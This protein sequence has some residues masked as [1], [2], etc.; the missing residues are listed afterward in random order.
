[1]TVGLRHPQVNRQVR[2]A[3]E[4]YRVVEGNAPAPV[5]F[6]QAVNAQLPAEAATVQRNGVIGECS[7][8]HRPRYDVGLDA[9][10][11]SVRLVEP[12]VDAGKIA[13]CDRG[14]GQRRAGRRLLHGPLRIEK[15]NRR[16][17][18]DTI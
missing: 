8:I 14:P 3:S 4:T 11:A 2:A 1:M 17:S 16:K 18:L 13:G 7:N 15:I 10:R 9:E 5:G 12:K 6:G